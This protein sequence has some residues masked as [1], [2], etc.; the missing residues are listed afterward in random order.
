MCESEIKAYMLFSSSKGNV[1]YV[2]CGSDEILIDAG[3]SAR[4]ICA[5]LEDIGTSI[6][7]IKAIFVTHEHNDHIGGLGTIS[8]H[9][10]IPI[11]APHLSAKYIA[12]KY[13][14]TEVL[15]HNNNAGNCVMLDNM[16]ISTVGT[17]HDSL[18]SVGFRIDFGEK[19][20]GYATDIGYL[21]SDVTN[22]LYGC[23]YVVIEANH[24]VAMLRN[25]DY[26]YY[27]KQRILSKKGHLSNSDCADFLPN[28]V[29]NGV[30]SIV[31]A[32]LSEN[33][34]RPKIAYGECRGRLV[35]SGISVSVNGSS[36]DVNLLV[37]APAC[38]VK[39]I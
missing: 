17:P 2:K 8:K 5:S 11:Y 1:A 6:E 38:A 16:K 15:L 31:L 32:H 7:N 39:I 23:N 37:A 21:S 3:V 24:D 26:P 10:K 36:G 22:M 29:E 35:S 4:R 34:N 20:F 33:N 19:S 30:E 18:A 12:K 14:T 13:P 27:L 25:G 9:H 28:L